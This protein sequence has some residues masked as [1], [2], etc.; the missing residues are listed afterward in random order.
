[1]PTRR[2]SSNNNQMEPTGNNTHRNRLHIKAML[3]ELEFNV[4]RGYASKLGVCTPVHP[5]RRERL[6]QRMLVA[7]CLTVPGAPSLLNYF[8][9]NP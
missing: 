2:G 9:E 1:M 4:A 3:R 8:T 7:S 6:L 5:M